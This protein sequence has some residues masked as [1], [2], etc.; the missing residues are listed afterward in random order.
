MAASYP[1]SIKSFT[2]K[3]D[4]IDDV[5]AEHVNSL[6]D[7]VVAIETALGVGW[8][9]VVQAVD[10]RT[11]AATDITAVIPADDT[12]PQISEGS[13]AMSVAIT[14]KSASNKLL[15]HVVFN[16]QEQSNLSNNMILA[17]FAA[18]SGHAGTDSIGAVNVNENADSSTVSNLNA[19]NAWIAPN[20]TEEIT[21]SLRVGCGASS[22]I[23]MNQ[24]GGGGRRLGGVVFSSV[25]V[26]E[27]KG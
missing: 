26:L 17:L 20:T 22:T 10:V 25:T 7:E 12:I 13:E 18:W 8:G 23:N 16:G 4:N 21:I 19:F 1:T 14:P 5:L 15:I 6:Q 3:Q 9:G 24:E 2:T 27:I 11:N